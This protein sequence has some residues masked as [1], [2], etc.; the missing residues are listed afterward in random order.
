[1]AK[2]QQQG[3]NT[4]TVWMIIFVALW[5]TATVFLVIL[6]T[7]Q[8][9]LRNENTRLAEDNRR[10]ISSGE[11][12]ALAM[13][14]EARPE[15]PT[16]VGLL[17][18]A[19]RLTA[20]LATGNKGQDD[21]G[22]VRTKRDQIMNSIAADKLVPNAREFTEISLHA[23]LVRLYEAYKGEHSLRNA[24]DERVKA[25]DE[26]VVKL[27]EL[28][29]SQKSDFDERAA[30]MAAQ[31]AEVEESR[32]QYRT[33]RDAAVGRLEKEFEDRLSENTAALTRER[34]RLQT[35]ER[36]K[37]ELQKRFAAQQER[38]GELLIGPEERST[39]RQPDGHVL[40]AVPGD[41]VVYI[42]LG[43]DDRLLLGLTFTVYTADQGIPADGRGKALI[44]VM[45]I[46]EASAECRIVRV[47]PNE[48]IIEG[49]LIANPVYDTSRSV[50]FLVAGD[51]D[52]DHDGRP[53]PDGTA[54]IEA[55]ITTWGGTVTADLSAL[56][57]FVV[58]GAPPRRPRT[59]AEEAAL[60]GI[61]GAGTSQALRDRYDQVLGS[62]QILSVP[63]LPQE[64]F[65]NFIGRNV[66][67]S[68][69]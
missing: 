50:T 47:A 58:L 4:I 66:G 34:Q 54:T 62:A 6:Y 22:A 29:A 61:G 9:E 15:G 68:R 24:A 5:L 26:E 48:V 32:S 8:E 21:A 52:L 55:I 20:E 42:N 13:F 3:V 60:D 49:D 1:M 27:A 17:E 57:D 44:E 30:K 64:I 12:T 23:G 35:L 59:A 2:G 37:N 63:I 25:L 41:D 18:G 33:E 38:F 36:D 40:M 31:L 67:M 56:T 51:F 69:R 43:Q 39:A 19:R 7:G 16:V 46:T 28:N 53:D 11:R 14:N 45:A 10:L 65:L